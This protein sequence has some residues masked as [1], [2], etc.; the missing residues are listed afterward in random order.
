MDHQ[1]SIETIR[2]FEIREGISYEQ[3]DGCFF[4]L[5]TNDGEYY[6]LNSSSS[7]IWSQL[8]EGKNNLKVILDEVNKNYTASNL[9]TTH[10]GSLLKELELLGLIREIE[11]EKNK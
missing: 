7:Y 11:I 8:I 6:E 1:E 5:N 2:I 10:V 9:I 4:I 3:I